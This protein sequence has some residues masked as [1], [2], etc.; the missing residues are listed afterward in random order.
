MVRKKAKKNKKWHLNLLLW[1][2]IGLFL[3]SEMFKFLFRPIYKYSL[4]A[5][6]SQQ[7]FHYFK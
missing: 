4:L 7:T 3:A 2:P 5:K 6:V 1:P